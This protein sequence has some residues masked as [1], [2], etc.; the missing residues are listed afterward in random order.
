MSARELSHPLDF[1]GFE[2]FLRSHSTWVS[3]CSQVLNRRADITTAQK[4][5][6]VPLQNKTTVNLIHGRGCHC[7]FQSVAKATFNPINRKD[8]F[9][10]SHRSVPSCASSDGSCAD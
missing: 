1:C 3:Q 8:I 6:N 4:F 9:S 5:P 7:R 10:T 2:H